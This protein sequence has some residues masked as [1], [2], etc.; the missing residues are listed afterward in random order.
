MAKSLYVIGIE[1]SELP[2]VTTLVGLLRHPDPAVG[3]LCRQALL[4][5][6][7]SASK[8]GLS[9]AGLHPPVSGS[10]PSAG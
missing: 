4:Y 6:Q 9:E 2:A 3:E 7:D 1:N 10:L 8:R 5:L